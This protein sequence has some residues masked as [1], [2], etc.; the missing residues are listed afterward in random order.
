MPAGS[1]ERLLAQSQDGQPCGH[2]PF[3][4]AVHAGPIVGPGPGT[5]QQSM[6]AAQQALPQQNSLPLHVPTLAHGGSAHVLPAQKGLS[7]M[8]TLPQPAQLWM[9]LPVLTHCPSQHVSPGA[10]A[11]GQGVPP[12]PVD[13]DDDVVVVDPVDAPVDPVAPVDVSP[14]PVVAPLAPPCPPPPVVPVPAPEPLLPVE[15]QAKSAETARASRAARCIAPGYTLALARAPA[16]SEGPSMCRVLAYLGEPILLEDLLYRPDVSFVNQTHRAALLRRLNLA[17]SGILAWDARSEQADLPFVYRTTQL[18]IYDRN[19]RALA[20]KVKATC[21]L[22]H[23]RGVAYDT[24]AVISEQNLHPFLFDGA[25]L[26]LAHNGQLAR[27][28]EMKFALVPHIKPELARAVRGSTDSEWV[29]ALLLSQLPDPHGDFAAQDIAGAVQATLR[30]L[31]RVRREIGITT[32]SPMNLFLSDGNDIVA[33][34]YSFDLGRYDGLGDDY[35][36]PEEEVLRIWYT[37]GHSYGLYGTEWRMQGDPGDHS[38]CII[39]SEPL[40]RDR[41]TWR[42][43]PMQ[44]LVYVRR[45]EGRPRVE[46]VPLDVG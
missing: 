29:Y 12:V 13:A 9:S 5:L 38:S 28:D 14:E 1:D 19:L 46:I 20:R 36:P 44:H 3:T 31:A 43:V 23:L 39:A 4:G 32:F 27:F 17:G 42:S 2:V 35:H 26:A 25:R 16:P 41:S 33:A 8:Q 24:R 22:A 11:G 15:P 37:T 6:P 21:A 45:T 34:C 40:T 18:A 10:H 7:P 30:V